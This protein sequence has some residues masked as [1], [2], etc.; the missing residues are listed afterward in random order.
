M[1]HFR[2][3]EL[4]VSHL[5]KK[6]I[7]YNSLSRINLVDARLDSLGGRF[8]TMDAAVKAIE[9]HGERYVEYVI[10]PTFYKVL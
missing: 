2:I 5:S 10:L 6:E 4:E 7:I 1:Q 9:E 3:Y 8:E